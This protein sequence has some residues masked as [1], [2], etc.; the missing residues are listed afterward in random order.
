VFYRSVLFAS[1]NHLHC[2]WQFSM[3]TSACAR[4]AVKHVTRRDGTQGCGCEQKLTPDARE[5]S[6]FD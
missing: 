3:Q 6:G 1:P 2:A 5:S 4:A